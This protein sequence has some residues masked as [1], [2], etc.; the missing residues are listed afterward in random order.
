MAQDSLRRPLRD[1]IQWPIDNDYQPSFIYTTTACPGSRISVRVCSIEPAIY[2]FWTA[3][4]SN[5]SLSQNLFF[6]FAGNC[7][8]NVKGGLGYWGA[9]G[10]SKR[11]ITIPK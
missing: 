10:T 9:Y 3:Y 4:D 11:S 6:T 7:P 8:G 2:D 1:A 5:I